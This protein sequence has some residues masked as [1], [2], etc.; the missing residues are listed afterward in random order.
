[1]N[2]GLV[3][4]IVRIRLL[5]VW[6]SRMGLVWLLAMPMVFSFIMGQ[7]MGGG[8]G[9]RVAA[10]LP[11][12]AI[13][14]A[15]HRPALADLLEPLHDNERFQIIQLD[16][17]VS[18]GR[19]EQMVEAG[20][21]T[22]VLL[23]PAPSDSGLAGGPAAEMTLYYNSTRLSSQ[24]VNTLLQEQVTRVNTVAAARA[25]SADSLAVRGADDLNPPPVF[26]ETVFRRVWAHPSLRLVAH[27]LGRPQ[28]E[29]WGLTN[30]YQHVGPAYI[31]FFVMMFVL[32]TAKSIVAARDNRTLARM[33][34]SRASSLE[35]VT[36]FFLGSLGVGIVQSGLLLAMNGL[37]FGIDYGDSPLALALMILLFAG[38][39]AGAAVLLGSTAKS[40][41][42]AD[43]LAMALTMTMA[44]LGGLWW[45]LEIVP[46]IMQQ[47]GKSLPTGQAITIFH[48]LIGRGYGVAEIAPLLLGL[49][50]WS[51]AVITL[52]AWRLRRLVTT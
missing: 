23:V 39:A 22:A 51:A 45:P 4:A 37:A 13:A 48:D 15:Q 29:D 24:T 33:V 7:I 31:L 8:N 26:D 2:W 47:I 38:F 12:L 44:A 10:E 18:A 16:S 17:L 6:R 27:T 1:M 34:T 3:A 32:Q 42:Q 19:A 43:G 9:T 40:G 36:G 52:G 25:L 30:A 14:A 21:W 49:G 50:L 5:Q 11:V 41:A 35:L 46:P 20:S 28:Q